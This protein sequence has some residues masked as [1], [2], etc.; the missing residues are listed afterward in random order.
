MSTAS[1]DDFSNLVDIAAPSNGEQKEDSASGGDNQPDLLSFDEPEDIKVE[2]KETKSKSKK[3]I[4]KKLFKRAKS[5]ISGAI[6]KTTKEFKKLSSLPKHHHSAQKSPQKSPSKENLTEEYSKLE[7]KLSEKKSEE[8]LA[9]QQMQERVQQAVSKTQSKLHKYSSQDEDEQKTNLTTKWTGFEEGTLEPE[10][11]DTSLNPSISVT[12]P[13][14]NTEDIDFLGTGNDN[15]NTDSLVSFDNQSQ[16]VPT[17]PAPPHNSRITSMENILQEDN[18]A[19]DAVTS[20]DLDFLGLGS[21]APAAP[22]IE[23]GSSDL[24]AQDVSEF[25]A[26]STSTDVPTLT[27]APVTSSFD[28]LQPVQETATA[29]P[30]DVLGGYSFSGSAAG[31]S[32]VNTGSQDNKAIDSD[33][34]MFEKP[35]D[36][37]T[38]DIAMVNKPASSIALENQPVAGFDLDSQPVYGTTDDPLGQVNESKLES[39]YD[40]AAQGIL[41]ATGEIEEVVPPPAPVLS[42]TNEPEDPPCDESTTVDTTDQILQ[43]LQPSQPPEVTVPLQPLQPREST[44]PDTL[45]SDHTESSSDVVVEP[46][47]PKPNPVLAMFGEPLMPVPISSKEQVVPDVSSSFVDTE[48]VSTAP[49]SVLDEFDC[50]DP[51]KAGFASAP[52]AP[53]EDIFSKIKKLAPTNQ[54]STPTRLVKKQP[55][56]F[57]FVKKALVG[58]EYDENTD[59]YKPMAS[60]SKDKRE[61][62]SEDFAQQPGVPGEP[63]LALEPEVILQPQSQ[64][65]TSTNPFMSASFTGEMQTTDIL[66]GQDAAALF[67]LE[68]Q[69]APMDSAFGEGEQTTTDLGTETKPSWMQPGAFDQTDFG[70]DV[71][72]DE[73]W[74][75]DGKADKKAA[76]DVWG[77]DTEEKADDVPNP[78]QDDFSKLD[79]IPAPQKPPMAAV[80]PFMASNPLTDAPLVAISSPSNPFLD[81]NASS[82]VASGDLLGGSSVAVDLFGDPITTPNLLEE[83]PASTD[84]LGVGGQTGML[85]ESESFFL[86]SVADTKQDAPSESKAVDDIFDPFKVSESAEETTADNKED[87]FSKAA[88]LG[89]KQL[90]KPT[91]DDDHSFMLDIKPA[92][93]RP[94]ASSAPIAIA[95]APPPKAPKSPQP[96]RE[97]PFDRDSPPEENFAQFEVMDSSNNVEKPKEPPPPPTK[98]LSTDSASTEEEPEVALE[99]LPPYIPEV[100]KDTFKLMLRYPTKKKIAGN[101]YWKNVSVKLEKQKEGLM[102]RVLNDARDPLPIQELPLQPCYSLS[103]FT[104]QQY[105]QYGKIHTVKLQYVF[106]KERVGIKTERITPSIVKFKKREKPKATMILD[107]SPQVSELLKFGSL[108]KQEIMLFIQKIEDEF[109]KMECRREKTLTYTKDEITAEVR[110]EYYAELDCNGRVLSQKARCRVFV[111][112]FLTGMPIVEIGLNDRRRKGKEVVGRCDIIPIKTEEWIKLE[113][114]EFHCSVNREEFEKTNN[115]KFQPLDAC[116]FELMRYRVRLRENKELPLQLTIQQILKQRKCEIRCDLLVTGYH[117]Y[118]KKHGQFPCEDIEVRFPIPEV[119]IYMFRYERRFGYG[120]VHSAARK[121]GKIK[122]LERLTMLTQGNVNQALMEADVGTAKYEHIYR[123]IVWRIPRLPIRNQGAYTSHL[124]RLKLELG[125]HDE[126]PESFETHTDVSFT[127]PCSTTSQSQIRSIAVTNPNP[128]EKWVRSTARYDYKIEIEHLDEYPELLAIGTVYNEATRVAGSEGDNKD[129]EE[130]EERDPRLAVSDTDSSDSD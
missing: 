120:S 130:P 96:P 81:T 35:I 55:D 5:P 104:L 87:E 32:S 31:D 129:D 11:I 62:V 29:D 121:P 88:A 20:D 69:I 114:V 61:S 77:G 99:P 23:N 113:N 17:C 2:T 123:S 21:S 44:V 50:F 43:P 64:M 84:L 39:T 53:V 92:T 126:I 16:S 56:H 54:P 74:D 63:G 128:P 30:S 45:D 65:E 98:S 94:K 78:F 4:A 47:A 91:D 19:K 118:S 71:E 10:V 28:P 36:E 72:A 119:W 86:D 60:I 117:S 24:L 100:E 70:L 1:F 40:T 115:I 105:D 101:R 9:F 95:L 48:P 122:G 111:L 46:S 51:M 42:T 116:Q 6:N 66:G 102:V 93:E 80:N 127:M 59:G 37:F 68:P 14:N 52:S 38:K 12:C 58:D 7:Q 34:L 103:E 85:H 27:P 18:Q 67:G 76:G 3:T 41:E 125:P 26:L 8:W 106:Y 73:A 107:H 57:S 25:D 83:T 112:A 97:N 124:F 82:S 13:T 49:T 110:D 22:A 75:D 15:Y 109:M 79:D 90:A 108:D 89:D 33:I